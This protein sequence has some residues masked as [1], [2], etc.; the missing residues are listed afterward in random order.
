MNTS[1]L[2]EYQSN[3]IVKAVVIN[4]IRLSITSKSKALQDRKFDLIHKPSTFLQVDFDFLLKRMNLTE[5]EI[6]TITT[7]SPGIPMTG[8]FVQ[9]EDGYVSWSPKDAFEEGYTEIKPYYNIGVK[10]IGQDEYDD[11]I[12]E[13]RLELNDGR[14]FN[15]RRKWSGSKAGGVIEAYYQLQDM[16]VHPDLMVRLVCKMSDYLDGDHFEKILWDELKLSQTEM[17]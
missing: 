6:K 11:G 14:V 5:E 3:K 12:Q 15:Q 4:H 16:S 10:S 9:Y 7:D 17:I 13:L 2:K 8:Y 1:D